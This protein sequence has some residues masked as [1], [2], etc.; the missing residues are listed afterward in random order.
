MSSVTATLVFTGLALDDH[1]LLH[2]LN[3]GLPDTT[4][5]FLANLTPHA[6]GRKHPQAL[7]FA[8]GFNYLDHAEFLAY[9]R[10]FPWADHDCGWAQVAMQGENN[11]GFVVMDIYRDG[12]AYPAGWPA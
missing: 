1:A 5:G 4:T 12:D 10:R 2:A 11:D 3:A 6:G 8:A 7:I 9:L